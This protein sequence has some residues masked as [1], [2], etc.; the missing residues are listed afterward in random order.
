MADW[1][2]SDLGHTD[3]GYVLSLRAQL[4][5]DIVRHAA[6]VTGYP[7]GNDPAGRSKLGLMPSPA[8]ASRANGIADALVT[9]WEQLGWV[10]PTT[11]TPD[12][13]WTEA[14]RLSSIKSVAEWK[15]RDEQYA[16]SVAGLKAAKLAAKLDAEKADE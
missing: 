10:R 7:D 1:F 2:P 13:E 5:A 15:R 12:E 9:E 11:M 14:G 3:K 4:A 16:N 6:L 8:V